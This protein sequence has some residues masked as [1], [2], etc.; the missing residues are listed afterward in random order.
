V[1]DPAVLQMVLGVLIREAGA[2]PVRDLR[3]GS[4]MESRCAALVFRE[5]VS[6]SC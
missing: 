1:L 3:S 4:K 6:A 2:V 5:L